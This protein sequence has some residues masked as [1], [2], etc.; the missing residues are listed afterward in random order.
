VLARVEWPPWMGIL[1]D[2]S[3]KLF[4]WRHTLRLN[5]CK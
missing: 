1:G 4:L 2:E 5:S 3:L